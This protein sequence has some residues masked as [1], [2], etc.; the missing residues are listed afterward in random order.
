MVELNNATA[1]CEY[2]GHVSLIFGHAK[3]LKFY[4][5]FCWYE[6][7]GCFSHSVTF[8]R[9]E[10]CHVL[11]QTMQNQ[12]RLEFAITSVKKLPYLTSA[13]SSCDFY[14]CNNKTSFSSNIWFGIFG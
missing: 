11:L 9:I 1:I 14:L 4:Q 3:T 8:S 2:F 7:L 10:V 6:F 13:L 5:A 12:T